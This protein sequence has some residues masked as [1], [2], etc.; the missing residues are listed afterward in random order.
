MKECVRKEVWVQ[1]GEQPQ[2][3][4]GMYERLEGR[5]DPRL[6]PLL[7]PAVGKVS[8]YSC[9]VR[10]S[11]SEFYLEEGETPFTGSLL[12]VTASPSW[13]ESAD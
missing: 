10:W 8:P 4:S 9:P 1:A 13:I 2:R 6:G 3:S 12:K 5:Q 11:G 7:L